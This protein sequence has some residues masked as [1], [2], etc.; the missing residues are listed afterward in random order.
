MGQV[1]KDESPMP[2]MHL[3]RLRYCQIGAKLCFGQ[4]IFSQM[5][6]GS[7]S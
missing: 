1:E 4:T 2:T 5:V 3:G 7:A 6:T